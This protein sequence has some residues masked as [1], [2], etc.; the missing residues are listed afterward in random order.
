MNKA[1]KT[2][3]QPSIS[4][5]TFIALNYLHN[6]PD[7]VVRDRY[8][9]IKTVEQ[10]NGK[11]MMEAMRRHARLT[12]NWQQALLIDAKE[13]QKIYAVNE[14]APYRPYAEISLAHRAMAAIIYQDFYPDFYRFQKQFDSFEEF[15]C[16]IEWD[17]MYRAMRG[18]GLINV[19]EEVKPQ[20]K[21]KRAEQGN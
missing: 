20:G 1:K 5:T 10:G 4:P 8:S 16:A 2:L 14:Q 19:T 3:P 15:W 21:R 6:L 11:I 12:N 9:D 13:L 7:Q 17:L 18:S